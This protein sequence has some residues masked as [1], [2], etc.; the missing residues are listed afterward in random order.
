MYLRLITNELNPYEIAFMTP[1][2]LFP[3]HWKLLI[4]ERERRDK[5]LYMTKSEARTNKFKCPRC[6]K[7]ETTYY[8]LQT[9]SADEPMT[10]F[11]TCLN[12]GKRWR[13]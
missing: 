1:Q 6:R 13:C 2:D 5:I 8:E 4:D 12:C 10:V 3:E 7:K 9:R 11:I